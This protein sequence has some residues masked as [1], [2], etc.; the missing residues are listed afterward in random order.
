[1]KKPKLLAP[2]N[3]AREITSEVDAERMLAS[4]SWV[5]AV[6]PRKPSPATKSQRKFRRNRIQAGYRRFDVL[7]PEHVFNAL[8]AQRREGE[9]FAQM[10]ERLIRLSGDIDENSEMETHN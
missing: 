3:S 1:M 10:V 9:T 8:H 2:R 5:L 6:V 4:G 7:L